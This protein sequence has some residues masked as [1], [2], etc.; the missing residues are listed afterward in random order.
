MVEGS[1][2]G[3]IKRQKGAH[4]S[5]DG[6]RTVQWEVVEIGGDDEPMAEAVTAGGNGNKRLRMGV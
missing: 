6:A 1:R 4:T 5:A 3:R 2:L